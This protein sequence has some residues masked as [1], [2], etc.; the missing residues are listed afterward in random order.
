M[1][2]GGPGQAPARLLSAGCFLLAGGMA[3]YSPH[4]RGHV[5]TTGDGL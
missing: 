5:R 2:S 1:I 3:S 4:V